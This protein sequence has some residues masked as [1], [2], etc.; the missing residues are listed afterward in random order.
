[1]R[2][3]NGPT[4]WYHQIKLAVMKIAKA[5]LIVHK[6]AISIIYI[7]RTPLINIVKTM[8]VA[9]LEIIETITK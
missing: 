7:A 5:I 6:Q 8:K 9:L 3:Q 1:M 4:A 2:F